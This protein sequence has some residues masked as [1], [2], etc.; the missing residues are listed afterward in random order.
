MK[1]MISIKIV[2]YSSYNNDRFITAPQIGFSYSNYGYKLL[3]ILIEKI[4]G[5]T[6][7]NVKNDLIINKIGLSNTTHETSNYDENTTKFYYKRIKSFRS[8]LFRLYF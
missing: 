6:I 2:F 5:K 3:G 4:S 7:Q 1:K 8:S